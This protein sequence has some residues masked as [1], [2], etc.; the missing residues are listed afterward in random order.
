MYTIL[1]KKNNVSKSQTKWNSIFETVTFSWTQIYNIP[2]KCCSNT[3]LQWFQYRIL[4]RIWATNDF[5]SNAILNMTTCAVSA[6]ENQ[7]YW[8]IY[9]GTVIQL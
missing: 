6:K 1:N 9:S 8:N 2:A 5:Y 3:K 7:K 4:Q